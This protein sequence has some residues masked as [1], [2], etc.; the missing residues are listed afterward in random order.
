MI[1]VR[2]LLASEECFKLATCSELTLWWKLYYCAAFAFMLFKESRKY[3]GLFRIVGG[4]MLEDRY[5]YTL[6]VSPLQSK[7]DEHLLKKRNVPHDESL[8]D[9]DVD[10]DFKGVRISSP[11]S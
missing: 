9:S 11:S 2:A 10:A 3:E 1:F 8:E 5:T 4:S 7:R 6:Y